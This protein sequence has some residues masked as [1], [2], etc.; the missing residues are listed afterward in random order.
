LS[1]AKSG[2]NR[3]A[4]TLIPHFTPFNPGY[5]CSIHPTRRRRCL[6]TSPGGG[7]RRAKR[8]GWGDSVDGRSV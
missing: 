2:N 4:Y 5:A 7:G 3:A 6:P 1:A 8:G